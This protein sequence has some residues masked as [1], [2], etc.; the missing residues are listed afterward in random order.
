MY[1]LIIIIKAY[2][3]KF[4]LLGIIHTFARKKKEMIKRSM[5]KLFKEWINIIRMSI[6]GKAKELK[7]PVKFSSC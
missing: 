7:V 2:I 3:Y 1:D 6:F 5:D 4:T